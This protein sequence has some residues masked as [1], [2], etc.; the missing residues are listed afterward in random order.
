MVVLVLACFV[1]AAVASASATP[2]VALHG[3]VKEAV[4]G[5]CPQGDPCDGIARQLTL[6]FSRQGRAVARATTNLRGQYRVRLRA[7]RYSVRVASA[8]SLPVRPR[9][10]RIGS[11]RKRVDFFVGHQIRPQ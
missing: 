4:S 6:V 2:R 11:M 1:G 10:V 5:T 7:G 8:S 3:I 9:R